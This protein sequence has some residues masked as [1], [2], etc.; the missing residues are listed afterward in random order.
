MVEIGVRAI[1]K[2]RQCLCEIVSDPDGDVP[3][4]LLAAGRSSSAGGR[5]FEPLP[6]VAS[7]AVALT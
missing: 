4:A 2:L 7:P 3:L 6:G 1:R 5:R